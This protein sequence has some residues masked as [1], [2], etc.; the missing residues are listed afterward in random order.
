MLA[1][2]SAAQICVR[3][4]KSVGK[5]SLRL[6]SHG[7]E[8][9]ESR[10]HHRKGRHGH[11]HNIHHQHGVNSGIQKQSRNIATN[12]L[13]TYSTQ[14]AV[15]IIP[16]GESNNNADSLKNVRI[17][18]P[19]E[20]VEYLDKHVIGQEAAKKTLAVSVYQHY[21]RLLYNLEIREEVEAAY[22]EFSNPRANSKFKKDDFIVGTSHNY[23]KLAQE[24]HEMAKKKPTAKNVANDLGRKLHKNPDDFLSDMALN[25][26][27]LDKS[28][29]VLVGPSGSGKTYLTQK[30]ACILDVPFALCDCTTLTQSGYVG[31]DA[32]SVIQ[33]L[34]QNADGDLERTQRGIVFLDEFDKIA[35]SCDPIHSANGM[36]DVSGRGVQQ[37]L[38]KIVEGTVCRVK[39]PFLQGSKIDIDTSGILFIASGAFNNLDKVVARRLEQ[40]SVG[41]GASSSNHD[42]DLKAKDETVVARKRDELLSQAEQS[43]LIGFG[44]IPE[45]VGRFPIVCAFHTLDEKAFVQVMS[46]PQNSLLNQA[47]RQF[48]IDG[49]KLEVTEDALH[50]IAS[51]AVKRKTG[52][53]ALRSIFEKVLLQ[54]KFDCPGNDIETLII[55]QATIES[56]GRHFTIVKKGDIQ[57]DNLA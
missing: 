27:T 40:R 44:M 8:L 41:F 13:L 57:K 43:D 24:L 2:K 46:D 56:Q 36:R 37:A 29:V 35:T 31:E 53:R 33:K 10:H 50:A 42:E 12:K 4:T 34:F 22:Q 14:K 23:S 21:R 19:R 45:V 49:I 17:P 39:N 25:P 48:A 15:E 11:G 9:I 6:S 51:Q 38:L 54:A 52:A 16:A 7:K 20:I 30:L 47:K 5:R 32:D 3:N 1:G 28:N 55:D 18:Y 26:P